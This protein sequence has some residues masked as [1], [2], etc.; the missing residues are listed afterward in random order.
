[1]KKKKTHKGLGLILS[2]PQ[3]KIITSASELASTHYRKIKRNEK[4]KTKSKVRI[5]E[6]FKTKGGIVRG[7][8]YEKK[9]GGG[10]S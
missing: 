6:G 3:S 9:R 5:T 10:L 4:T 2:E 8:N 7:A 1:M